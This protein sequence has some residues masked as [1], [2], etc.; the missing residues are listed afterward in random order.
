MVAIEDD[1]SQTI[2]RRASSRD[3]QR[4][5]AL[6]LVGSP[7]TPDTLRAAR[8]VQ[9][10]DGLDIGRRPPTPD[11]RRALA[12]PDRTVSSLHARITRNPAPEKSELYELS[13]LGSTNGTYV[14]GARVTAPVT[15]RPGALIFV[16]SQVMVFRL[17]TPLE[18]AAIE[19]D[20]ATPF[21]PVPTLSPAMAL[22]C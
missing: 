19:E 2:P 13:D 5:A 11:G 20:I 17:L 4:I 15:L 21:A 6:L 9:L 10:G 7:G 1:V 12:L 3:A 16:G 8:V 18:L 22:L 14:D